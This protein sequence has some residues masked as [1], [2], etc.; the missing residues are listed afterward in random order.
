MADLTLDLNEPNKILE[1]QVRVIS[2]RPSHLGILEMMTD[3]GFI[4]LAINKNVAAMLITELA[5]FLVAQ[6]VDEGPYEDDEPVN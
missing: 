6:D 5:E 1:C 4:P 3:Q 2:V